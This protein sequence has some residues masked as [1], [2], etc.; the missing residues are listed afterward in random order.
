MSDRKPT[1]AMAANAERGLKL[2]EEFN[3][4]GTEVGVKRAR[5]IAAR[6]ELS[7]EDVRSMFSYFARHEVD[8]KADGFGDA[9]DPSPGYVAWLLWGGDE[10]KDFIDRAHADLEKG[11]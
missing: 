6:E 10:G 3:R 8:K 7:D 1:A 11:A 9:K 5:Q 4:G 2:R